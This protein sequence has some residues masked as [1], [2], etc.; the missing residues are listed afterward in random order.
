MDRCSALLGIELGPLQFNPVALTTRPG[1]NG[2]CDG[3]QHLKC[4]IKLMRRHPADIS[5]SPELCDFSQYKTHEILP[6]HPDFKPK[7]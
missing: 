3:L 6:L 7:Q 4:N 5:I 1:I 2:T